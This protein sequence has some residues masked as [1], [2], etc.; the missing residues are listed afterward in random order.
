MS[1]RM[2]TLNIF[3]SRCVF[4]YVHTLVKGA[5][6]KHVYVIPAFE[7]DIIYHQVYTNV[8]NFVRYGADKKT[9]SYILHPM[10]DL[11]DR[12]FKF[13]ML[14]SGYLLCYN[15]KVQR[16][17]TT[18]SAILDVIDIATTRRHHYF[19]DIDKGYFIGKGIWPWF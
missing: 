11:C 10:G 8:V 14:S 12:H 15:I 17:H 3:L 2:I 18:T 7:N 13:A 1:G 5:I 19:V 9:D 6:A 4:P 16:T